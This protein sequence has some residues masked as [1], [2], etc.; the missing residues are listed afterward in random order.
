MNV[1]AVRPR[2]R[3]VTAV[4][5]PFVMYN[6]SSDSFY[7]YCIDLLDAMSRI[8]GFDYDL[9]ESTDKKFGHMSASGEWNGMIADLLNDT[10]DFAVSALWVTH[11]R[12]KVR[13]SRHRSP[14]PV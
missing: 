8:S 1:T 13:R 9:T 12:R 11:L 14:P 4:T 2:Y 6:G 7:G 3:V 10:A 5:A